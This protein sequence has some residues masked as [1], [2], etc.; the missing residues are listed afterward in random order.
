LVSGIA[1]QEKGFG[2]VQFCNAGPTPLFTREAGDDL[3][4]FAYAAPVDTSGSLF[5]VL[6]RD[7]QSCARSEVVRRFAH[8][9]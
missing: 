8:Q 1:P 4:V 3:I 9:R 6:S 2:R 7:S 5:C